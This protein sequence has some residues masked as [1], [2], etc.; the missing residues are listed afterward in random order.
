MPNKRGGGGAQEEGHGEGGTERYHVYCVVRAKMGLST[1]GGGGVRR[2][3][4]VGRGL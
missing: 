3:M 1:E 4:E 2:C